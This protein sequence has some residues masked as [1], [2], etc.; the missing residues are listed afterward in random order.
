M[1]KRYLIG[2]MLVLALA[3]MACEGSRAP[4][5][6]TADPQTNGPTDPPKDELALLNDS[7]AMDESR[8]DLYLRRAQLY[9]D[10]EQVGAAMMDVNQAVTID[11]NNIDAFL[12][13]SDI[14][15]MLGDE[16]NITKTLNRALDVDPYDTRPMIKMAELNLLKQ[17]Y[18]LAFGYIDKALKINTYN[19]KAYFV[20]GMTYMARQ[21]TVAALKN[22]MVAREQD[23]DFVD[24]V[25]EIC[26]I[27]MAQDHP[28]TEDFLRN[29]V[30]RFPDEAMARYDLALYLQDHGAPEEALEHYDSLLMIQ[31]ENS[32][33][34]FNKGYVYFIYLGEN[35]K[36][37]EYFNRALDSDPNYLDALYNKG[38]VLEQMGNYVQ[39]KEIYSQVLK[40]KPNYRLAVDA[41]N[42]IANQLE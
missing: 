11:P 16:P 36:A 39:A 15:Y 32:R 6:P 37:L 28:L 18:N 21:D 23:A 2:W 10:R 30:D 14:Y 34:L 38:H 41:M 3:M 29:T 19:P 26:K 42:R 7:I 40:Q 12:L 33:L 9:F 13:L 8:S 4:K 35:Q 5:D 22:F 24:P 25:R 20:R 1:R 27:Y 31:P 17:N